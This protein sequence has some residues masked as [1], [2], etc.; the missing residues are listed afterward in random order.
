MQEVQWDRARRAMA[1]SARLVAES[2][3]LRKD[4]ART[5][6]QT[7]KLMAGLIQV[8]PAARAVSGRLRSAG[9]DLRTPR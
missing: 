8:A 6:V 3:V 5:V 2:D 4:V 7:S 9:P 1:E